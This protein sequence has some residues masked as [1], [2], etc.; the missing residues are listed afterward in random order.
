MSLEG[1]GAVQANLLFEQQALF[2]RILCEDDASQ[3]SLQEGLAELEEALAPF[4]VRSIQIAQGV[5]DPAIELINR[6]QPHRDGVFD[7]RV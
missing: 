5:E 4:S 1:L 7:A 6:L 2:V 3:Q